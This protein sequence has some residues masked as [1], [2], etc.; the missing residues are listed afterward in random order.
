MS[1]MLPIVVMDNDEWSSTRDM[2]YETV[3]FG[4]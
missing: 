3:S 1:I 2:N 4:M